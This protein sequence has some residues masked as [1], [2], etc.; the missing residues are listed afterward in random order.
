MSEDHPLVPLDTPEIQKEE[1]YSMMLKLID[2]GL[3]RNVNLAKALHVDDETI[4][5]WKKTKPVQKAYQAAVLKYLA[6]RKDEE[7]ILAELEVDTPQEAPKTLIQVNYQPIFSGE[8]LNA[9]PASNG[10]AQDLQPEKEN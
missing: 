6:K 5:I 10:N 9:I 4:A 1:E 7:K 3:W 8:S 2:R